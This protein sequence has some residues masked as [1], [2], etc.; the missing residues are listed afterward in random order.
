MIN[1]NLHFLHGFLGLKSD[2]DM[3]E[4]V[5]PRYSCFTYSI[6]DFLPI[7]ENSSENYFKN[8]AKNFNSRVFGPN[9]NGIKSHLSSRNLTAGFSASK[10]ILVGYSLGGRLALH[11]LTEENSWDGAIIISANPGLRTEQEKKIRI[12][13]DELW[14]NRFLHEPWNE[15]LN[16]WNAQEVFQGQNFGLLREEKF[17]NKEKIYKIMTHF[18]LGRQ[19]DLRPEIKNLQIPIL[20]ISGEQDKKFAII[21]KEMESLSVYIKSIIVPF[22]G[23]RVPWVSEA[24]FKKISNDFL[25]EKYTI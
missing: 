4:K 2:W 10:N 25:Q 20:W 8:W 21:G 14:A 3:I 6:E 23:H 15:V 16:A 11:S 18:S 17:Y 5:F 12:Q 22:A 7:A 19:N 9:D 24:Q 13:N 1:I